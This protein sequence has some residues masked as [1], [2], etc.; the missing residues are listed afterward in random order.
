MESEMDIDLSQYYTQ[1]EA[2]AFV[3]VKQ[4]SLKVQQ[5]PMKV[6]PLVYCNQS[7]YRKD[8]QALLN[9]KIATDAR[10]AREAAKAAAMQAGGAPEHMRVAVG[11]AAQTAQDVLTKAKTA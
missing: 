8:D 3:G 4:S 5:K 7:W 11:C 6:F 9:W 10:K 2:A 1:E